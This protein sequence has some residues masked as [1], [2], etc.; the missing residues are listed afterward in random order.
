MDLSKE[1][2]QVQKSA[3]KQM[4]L[5][6][7]LKLHRAI[8]LICESNPALMKGDLK[9]TLSN[10]GLFYLCF[11]DKCKNPATK[12]GYCEQHLQKTRYQMMEE[13]ANLKGRHN[14]FLV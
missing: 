11:Q 3:D 5:Y 13:E 7:D 4:R 12:K 10:G 1:F 2:A 8:D 6:S 14:K 9:K